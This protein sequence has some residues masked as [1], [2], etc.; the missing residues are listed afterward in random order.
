MAKAAKKKPAKKKAASA[1][2]GLFDEVD[3]GDDECWLVR[4]LRGGRLALILVSN[5]TRPTGSCWW[6]IR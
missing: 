1:Q 3:D 6:I 2:R 5:V 4:L